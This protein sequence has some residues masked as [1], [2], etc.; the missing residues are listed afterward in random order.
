MAVT[1][2]ATYNHSLIKN[3]YEYRGGILANNNKIY[4]IPTGYSTNQ[5]IYIDPTDDS[6]HIFG[7]VEDNRYDDY[8]K[9]VLGGDG[10]IY[11]IPYDATSILAIDPATNTT[12]SFGSNLAFDYYGKWN[13]GVLATNGKIYS[14][15]FGANTILCIDPTTSTASEIGNL[16]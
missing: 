3:T 4:A 1:V 14:V 12:S 7:V 10:K 11:C 9:A 2:D 15:P 16:G 5:L 13:S 8:S 6:I